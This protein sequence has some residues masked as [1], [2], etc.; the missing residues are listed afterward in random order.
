MNKDV[1]GGIALGAPAGEARV[2]EVDICKGFF[3]TISYMI[4][5]E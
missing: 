1:E 5:V 2:G 3:E 4:N